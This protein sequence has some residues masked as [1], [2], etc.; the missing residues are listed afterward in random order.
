M[1]VADASENTPIQ[2]RYAQRFAV[3]REVNRKEQEVISAQI[4]ELQERLKQLKADEV[5][6]SDMQCVVA[7]AAEQQSAPVVLDAGAPAEAASPQAVP[8]PRQETRT[9]ETAA[10]SRA[11]KTAR[12]KASGKTTQSAPK[13]TVAKATIAKTGAKKSAE[14]PLSELVL[15]LLLAHAGEPRLTREV[16]ADLEAAHPERATTVQTV[17][18]ILDN[19]A[20]KKVIE[21]E[22]KQG[23][24][25]YT[26]TKPADVTPTS[27]TAVE[28]LNE[29]ILATA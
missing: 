18:N 14:P 22:K 27:E 7:A 12:A 20:N 15:G 19:L 16:H 4:T 24:A 2:S 1:A 8:P 9:K 23:S 25:M 28:D 3:D 21:K 17:R 11:K 13:K 5:L 10:P 6:L 29:K 26:A